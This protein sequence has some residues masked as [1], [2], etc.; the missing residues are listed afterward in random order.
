M[1][2]S[3]P[4][5]QALFDKNEAKFLKL[6]KSGNYP[7]TETDPSGRMLLSSAVIAEM[8][9]AVSLLL[10]RQP[11]PLARDEKGWTALHFASYCN[12]VAIA[13]QL[14]EV[15]SAVDVKDNAGNTPLGRAVIEEH[16][17]MVAYLMG[18]GADAGLKNDNGDSP[19]DLAQ[20]FGYEEIVGLLGKG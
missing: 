5:F 16:A 12:N 13:K 7:F 11:E 9:E 2:K 18:A 20:T 3:L 15:F 14:L 6:A 10:E 19:L 4:L 8:P 1:K 17:E